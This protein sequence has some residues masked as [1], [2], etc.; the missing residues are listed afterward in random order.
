MDRL[1]TI[2]NKIEKLRKQKIKLQT[3]QALLFTKEAEKI[4]ED[5]FS[6]D[7]ALAALSDWKT[8]TESKKKEWTTRSHSFRASS[9]KNSHPK[10][11]THNPTSLQT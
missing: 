6:P 5:G 3:Q 1:T 7:I 2:D 9:L 11:E 4:F 10:V 8:A